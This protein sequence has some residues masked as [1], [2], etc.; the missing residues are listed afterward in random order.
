MTSLIQPQHDHG[1]GDHGDDRDRDREFHHQQRAL[2]MVHRRPA[3]L[4]L[5]DLRVDAL[6][7]PADRPGD[8]VKLTPFSS[9]S[10]SPASFARIR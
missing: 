4:H 3:H 7:G 9:P 6:R 1:R 5:R 2:G 10:V 8:G